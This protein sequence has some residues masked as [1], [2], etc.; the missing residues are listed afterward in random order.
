MVSFWTRG[1]TAIARGVAPIAWLN[2]IGNLLIIVT[3]GAVRLT[4]SGLGCSTWPMCTTESWVPQAE[5]GIH[6]IIEF[7]NRMMS[8][9]LVILAVLALLATWATRRERRD[10]W[11]LAL[12]IGG[13]VVLQAVIGGIVVLTRL[14]MS[15]VGVHYIIS[16]ALAGVCAAFVLRASRPAGPRERAIPRWL[17][18]VTHVSSL[19][20]ALVVIGGVITTG[21]GPH[22]GDDE[23]IRDAAAWEQ[24][25]HLHAW[26]GYAFVAVLVV[27]LVGAI[28]VRA[29]RYL[30]AVI[31]LLVTVAVQIVVGIVQA[32]I[33]IPPL[34]VGI[35]MLLAGIT[36]ALGVVLVDATKRPAR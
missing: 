27:L 11:A 33:G 21:N 35:H 9:V 31:V 12:V 2:L 7:S 15:T 13:G 24:L 10:L 29:R 22:S 19:L 1:T 26:L 14:E 28:A 8:P 3:G 20:L 25:V 6:G 5:Q 16:A 17:L 18:I 32:R 4:A 23:V 36:V 30:V 34:L